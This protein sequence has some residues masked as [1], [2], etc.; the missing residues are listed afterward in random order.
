MLGILTPIEVDG[1][2]KKVAANISYLEQIWQERTTVSRLLV[3]NSALT[4]E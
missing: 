4:N 1:R 3:N 2:A